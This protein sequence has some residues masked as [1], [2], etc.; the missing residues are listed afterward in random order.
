LGTSQAEKEKNHNRI[1]AIAAR[2]VRE[3]GFSGVG[4]ADLMK[5]VGL[6]HGGFYRHFGSRDDLIGEAVE[7]AL[8]E[9]RKRIADTPRTARKSPFQGI[10]DSYLSTG[11]RDSPGTGCAVTALSN[12]A[13]RG[14]RRVRAAYTRQVR[15]YLDLLNEMT[16]WKNGR[17]KRRNSVLALSALVGA[18]AMARAVDD[19]ELSLEILRFTADALK[20][21]V[22]SS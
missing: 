9:G 18:V 16:D 4:V 1:V 21:L 20:S 3:N 15:L 7:R 10:V 8:A 14:E 5:E 12:D 6:T 17:A 13:W 22:V 2:R 19:E 11:H